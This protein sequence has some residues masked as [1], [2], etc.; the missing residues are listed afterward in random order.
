ML[1][2]GRPLKSEYSCII[3]YAAAYKLEIS[4]QCLQE[5]PLPQR[6]QRV[7]FW[8]QSKAICDLLLVINTNLPPIL[9]RLQIMA[10]YWSNFR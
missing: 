4:G 6:I 10:D 9:H 2:R 7:R 8:H 1:A 5:A 3:L